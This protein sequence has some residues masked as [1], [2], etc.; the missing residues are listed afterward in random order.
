MIAT[1]TPELPPPHIGPAPGAAA[2]PS[3]SVTNA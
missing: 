2:R 1:V 3:R